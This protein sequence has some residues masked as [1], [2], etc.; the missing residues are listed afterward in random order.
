M[1]LG[2]VLL[3]FYEPSVRG[4]QVLNAYRISVMVVRQGI[5]CMLRVNMMK[6]DAG[7]IITNRYNEIAANY[8][9]RAN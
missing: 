5:E 7:R 2:I 4:E 1:L 3:S 9:K 8:Q 6:Y